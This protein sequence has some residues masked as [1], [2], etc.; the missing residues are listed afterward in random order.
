VNTLA[1]GGQQILGGILETHMRVHNEDK[2]ESSIDGWADRSSGKWND[3][4]GY[5]AN[6]QCS[7]EG[8]VVAAMNWAC[9]R[10][11]RRVIDAAFDDLWTCGQDVS[12]L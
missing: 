11:R 2:D 3:R 9:S 7:L 4:Q 10:Y 12:S 8:P 5:E 6:R 1:G